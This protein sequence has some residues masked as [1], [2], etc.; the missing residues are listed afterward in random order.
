MTDRYALDIA[1]QSFNPTVPP[2]AVTREGGGRPLSVLYSITGKIIRTQGARQA[3]RVRIASPGPEW[4]LSADQVA[5][6]QALEASGAPFT[7]TL[8]P[9]YEVS[10]TWGGCLLDGDALFTPKRGGQFTNY[11]FTIL[12]GGL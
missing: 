4:V 3:I 2:E 5:T 10:G 12:L 8:G 7:V 1:G 9:G 11:D 6:L